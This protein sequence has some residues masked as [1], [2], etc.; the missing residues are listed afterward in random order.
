MLQLLKH[1]VLYQGHLMLFCGNVCREARNRF[2]HIQEL[3]MTKV[4]V[5][6]S[7]GKDKVLVK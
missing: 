3:G 4:A 2:M 6:K 7:M 1:L 5:Y